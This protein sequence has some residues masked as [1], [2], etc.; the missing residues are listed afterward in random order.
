MCIIFNS[1]PLLIASESESSDYSDFYRS[2]GM[3][4]HVK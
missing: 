2:D 3:S 1:E 4:V